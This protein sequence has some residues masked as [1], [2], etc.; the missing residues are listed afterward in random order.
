MKLSIIIPIYNEIDYIDEIVARINAVELPDVI[1]DMEIILVD[2]GSK[3]GS[4]EKLAK[5]KKIN[6]MIVHE[7][8]HNFGKGAAIRTGISFATG[9]ILLIQDAD[10][11]YDPNDYPALLKPMIEEGASVVYGSRFLERTK[12]PD[13][14]AYKNW[15][16]N[17]LLRGVT[18]IL[19]GSRLTDEATAYKLFKAE[20]LKGIDLKSNRF[21]FCSEVTA[22][23]LKEGFRITEVPIHYKGR[24]VEE[25]KK[26]RWYDGLD[27]IWT[28][29]KYRF[30]D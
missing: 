29:L 8:G 3:D 19:Y 30:I 1:S 28:L 17:I 14:M 16:I 13:G 15:L 27:A 20:V 9:G 26:I 18:N 11:E 25:G 24:L 21:G 4:I 12:R 6:A 10:L 23:V 5:Y 2:D 22:K 7:S